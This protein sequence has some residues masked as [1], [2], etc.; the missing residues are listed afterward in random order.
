MSE[1]EYLPG[2]ITVK[3]QRFIWEKHASGAFSIDLMLLR[4]DSEMLAACGALVL[5]YPR[6]AKSARFKRNIGD[7]A[8][9]LYEQ[10][11]AEPNNW[12]AN[13]IMTAGMHAFNW[14]AADLPV[15]ASDD[16]V[17]ETEDFTAPTPDDGPAES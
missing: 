9:R 7:A 1:A 10:L 14:L 15:T 8:Q 17:K 3:G 2:E 12:T 11:I 13:E 5:A 4:N 6:M 16:E